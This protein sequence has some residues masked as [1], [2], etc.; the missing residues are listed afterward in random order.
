MKLSIIIPVLN[1]EETIGTVLQ[2]LLLLDLP[3]EKE[4]IAVDD[5][6]TDSSSAII[7]SMAS[8]HSTIKA[9]YC[10]N[11][12]GK[13][14]AIQKAIPHITGDMVI[15]QDA[16]LEYDT[17]DYKSLIQHIISNKADIVFGSRFLGSINNM[18]FQYL[19]ANKILTIT[20]NLIY[21][22]SLTDEATAYKLFKT[23]IFK[24]FDIRS[25]GFE[26]CPEVVAKSARMNCRIM[27]I[28][29]SYHARNS[30]EGKKIKWYDAF[31]A[32]YT[33]L[34]YR[35]WKPAPA[36]AGFSSPQ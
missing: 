3:A 17:A 7:N 2:N 16:D 4:I 29:V 6:S 10:K 26:F 35:F 19:L 33:L 12:Q 11:R 20:A 36:P 32:V 30:R 24:R 1:E 31:T 5:G 14:K 8:S 21:G 9:V 15:I 13:G 34:K 18:K 28:P 27:E 25:K 23:D 22:L